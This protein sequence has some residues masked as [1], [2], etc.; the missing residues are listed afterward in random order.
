M[1]LD[2]LIAQ[3]VALPAEVRA[4]PVGRDEDDDDMHPVGP[5]PVLALRWDDDGCSRGGSP[6]SGQRAARLL[7]VGGC[8]KT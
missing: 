8:P 1:T 5:M 4:L 7:G 3:L 2:D 6:R